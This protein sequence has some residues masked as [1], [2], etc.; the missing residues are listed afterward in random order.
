MFGWYIF[1]HFICIYYGMLVTLVLAASFCL[2]MIMVVMLPTGHCLFTLIVLL[3]SHAV[4]CWH[5]KTNGVVADY[6]S[7]FILLMLWHK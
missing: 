1:F 5:M 2:V 7:L 3:H 4:V 6:G